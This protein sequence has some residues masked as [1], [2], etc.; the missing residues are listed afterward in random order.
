MTQQRVGESLRFADASVSETMAMASAVAAPSWSNGKREKFL[1]G[2][3]VCGKFDT[4]IS[5][6]FSCE[7]Q[8][9]FVVAAVACHRSASYRVCV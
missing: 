3:N 9:R 4:I 7:N 5:F 2:W 8:F 6:V 1:F